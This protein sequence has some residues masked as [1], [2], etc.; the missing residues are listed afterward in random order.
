[1]K[2]VEMG[3]DEVEEKCLWGYG[4]NARRKETTRKTWT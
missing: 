3:T 1:V 4:G 2:E